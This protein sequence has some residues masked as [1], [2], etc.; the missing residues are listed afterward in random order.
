MIVLMLLFLMGLFLA[1]L[2]I[3]E[4]YG[5]FKAAIATT[6]SGVLF[7]FVVC[8]S[9]YIIRE[10]EQVVVVQFGRAIDKVMD[11]GLKFKVPFIQKVERFDKRALEWEGF[12]NE[13]TTKDKRFIWLDTAARWRIVDPLVFYEKFRGG[14]SEVLAQSRLDDIIDAAARDLVTGQLLVEVVRDSNRILDRDLVSLDRQDGGQNTGELIE[15]IEVGR[16]RVAQMILDRAGESIPA[17]WGVQLVDVRIKRINYVDSVRQDVFARMISERNRIA[18][19]YLSEGKGEAAE[20]IGQKEREL[21]SIRSEAYRKVEELKGDADAEAIR[22]YADSHG[23]DP[24]FYAFI[25]TLGTYQ[26]VVGDNTRLVL[27]TD[28][29]LYRYLEKAGVG[30]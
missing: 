20:I 7:L 21:K 6:I 25:Q 2:G 14:N 1:G 9:M 29:D 23:R 13:I 4:K 28:S 17:D 19:K 15:T 11:S 18:A 12:P 22:I 24:E 30:R 10:D 26:A 5:S 27:S 16:N 3:I 8:D